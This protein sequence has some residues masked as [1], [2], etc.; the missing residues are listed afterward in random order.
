M[1]WG[2]IE[3]WILEFKEWGGPSFEV[4]VIF[5]KDFYY[6]NSYQLETN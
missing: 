2:S 3:G 4:Y 1:M 6:L 5:D